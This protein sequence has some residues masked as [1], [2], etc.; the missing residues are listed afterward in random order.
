MDLHFDLLNYV[1]A[2]DHS[3]NNNVVNETLL[4]DVVFSLEIH[5]YLLAVPDRNVGSWQDVVSAEA[6]HAEQF[7][8]G[9]L[10]R[11]PCCCLL[12]LHTSLYKV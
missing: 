12:C 1:C 8:K 2:Q 9:Q 10:L 4:H 3:N 5:F 6:I 7:S 11:V